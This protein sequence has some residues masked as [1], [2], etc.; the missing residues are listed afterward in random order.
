MSLHPRVAHRDLSKS[1]P[2]PQKFPEPEKTFEQPARPVGQP[3]EPDDS[4][5]NIEILEYH[6]RQS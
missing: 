6:G 1:F 5:R 2:D 4:I 3:E